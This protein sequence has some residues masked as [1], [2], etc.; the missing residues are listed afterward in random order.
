[1]CIRDSEQLN[2]PIAVHPANPLK[3]WCTA[4][5]DEVG[6]F[7]EI[8]RMEKDQESAENRVRSIVDLLDSMDPDFVPVDRP[9]ADR[10]HR[11]LEHISLDRERDEEDEAG[12][13]VTLITVHSCKGLEFPHVFI[14]G[15][16]DGLIPHARSK[17]EGTLDEERRLFYVAITRAQKT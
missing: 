17:V 6:L 4:W 12:D 9:A 5:L 10:L 8:R 1:M 11:F 16:E 2:R 7:R 13:A 15:M 14:A 3:A